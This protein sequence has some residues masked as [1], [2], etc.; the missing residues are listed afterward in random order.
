MVVRWTG[1]LWPVVWTFLVSFLLVSPVL[2]TVTAEVNRNVITE[3]ETLTL[4]ITRSGD[5]SGSP[6]TAPLEKDFEILSR[7]KGSSYSVVNGAVSSSSNWRLMLRPRRDGRL[8]IPAL[9]VGAKTTQPIVIEVQKQASRVAPG[10]QPKGNVWLEMS[11]APS[12]VWVQQQ[13]ILTVKIFQSVAMSDAQLSDPK[14]QQAV[15]ERL[16]KDVQ[17]DVMRNGRRWR[18]TQRNY[19]VFPQQSGLLKIEPVQLDAGLVM[20]QKSFGFS[21]LQ[22]TQPL[23]VRSNSLQLKVKPIPQAWHGQDWLPASALS[24]VEDWP[25]SQSFKV[26]E[27]ITRS[28]TLR[29]VGLANSQLPQVPMQLPERLKVYPDQPNLEDVKSGQGVVGIRTQKLAIIPTAP[30]TYLLPQIKL[31]WWNV[32]T[33]RMETATLSARRFTVVGVAAPAPAPAP[34]SPTPSPQSN[35]PLA[36]LQPQQQK[37][38]STIAPAT[39]AA[40]GPAGQWKLIALFAMTGW[41]ITVLV[42]YVMKW[43]QRR[44]AVADNTAAATRK[45]LQTALAK[46]HSACKNNDAKACE[47]AMSQYAA[48]RWPTTGGGLRAWRTGASAALNEQLNQLERYLYGPHQG[49]WNG[50]DMRKA[51]SSFMASAKR[52]KATQSAQVLPGLYPG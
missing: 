31:N 25:A 30:G 7:S 12:Q 39:V 26:G 20:N 21:L 47:Q 37:L 29:A 28:L 44:Q 19:A 10:G 2:A 49:T 14:A 8:T 48:C 3:G 9:E 41:F 17:Y 34:V 6:D 40:E 52:A 35:V 18:V 16:G 36:Q 13:V 42:F 38:P 22:P 43:K 23:R 4:M 51:I 46:I 50:A 11:L 5:D 27:P 32:R 45:D 24:L 1:Q 33:D 15:I